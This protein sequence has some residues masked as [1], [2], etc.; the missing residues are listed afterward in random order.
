[1]KEKIKLFIN[2][3]L[4]LFETMRIKNM[5]KTVYLTFDDGPEPDIIQFVL[6]QLEEHGCKATFFCRGDNAEKYPGLLKQI[7]DMG[8]QLGNH[9]YSHINSF[10][11]PTNDYVEDVEKADRI[12]NTH[13]FRPPWGSITLAAFLRLRRK[14]RIIYWSLVSGDTELG[15]LDCEKELTRLKQE[16]KAGDVILFHSCKRHEL[17]TKQLLPDYLDWLSENGYHSEVIE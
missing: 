17:E 10:E 4:H 13:L 6:S 14:Y 15:T 16:T 9:T 11:T 1:M 8:H 5:S 7:T 3:V 12:L 2:R